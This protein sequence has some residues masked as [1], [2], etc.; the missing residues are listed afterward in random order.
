M[1][2][3]LGTTAST[4]AVC[5]SLDLA[6]SPTGGTAYQLRDCSGAP[7]ADYAEQYPVNEATYGDIVA[8][9]DT[10][11]TT[12]DGDKVP[13]L[14][15][16]T[17][18]YQPTMIGVVS[19]NYG[20]FTSAGYNISEEDHPMPI[21]LN[22]RVLV[23]VSKENGPIAIGDPITTSS[24]PGTGMK[25]TANGMIIGFALNI[26]DQA[27]PGKIMVFINLGWWN[28]ATVA[29]KN[30]SSQVSGVVELT[31]E[32]DLDM[33]GRDIINVRM[34]KGINETWQID[35]DGKMLVREINVKKVK[36]EEYS[37]KNDG[38]EKSVGR[39]TVAAGSVSKLVINSKVTPESLIVLTFEGNP[40]SAWWI[41]EKQNGSFMVKFAATAPQEI[42]F[43]YWIVGVD[44]QLTMPEPVA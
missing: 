29:D 32:G 5:S 36:S 21:A 37:V 10:M 22:G 34:I 31:A 1:S 28:G 30:G 16:S 12:K 43:V 38:A 7:A 23:N 11:I 35:A 26:F 2:V 9:S 33:A 6:T 4:T 8:A 20:D 27:E 3:G 42:R 14:V 24:Q 25:A 44:G 19:N 15:K 13:Q 17:A 18:V 39:E 41:D 40:G